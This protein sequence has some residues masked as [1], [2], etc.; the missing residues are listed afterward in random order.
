MPSRQH[1]N[2]RQQFGECIGFRQIIVTAGA[3]TLDAVVDLS[4]RRKNQRRRAITFFA[5]RTDD[6]EPVAFGKHHV[7][8]RDVVRRGGR[9]GH[10]GLAI[11]RVIHHEAGLFQAAGDEGGD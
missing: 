10:A 7:D 2:P 1:F 5:Q 6:R 11:R 4:E 3:Q 9:S 8:D